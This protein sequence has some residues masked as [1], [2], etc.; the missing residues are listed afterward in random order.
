MSFFETEFPRTVGF[1]CTGGPS[2]NTT[3]NAGFSGVEQRNKNWSLARAMYTVDLLTPPPSQF[4]GTPQQFIDLVHGF[5]LVVSGKGDAFRFYDHK[6]NTVT[7]QQIGIGDGTNKSFQLIKSYTVGNRTYTR[8]IK[9]P[10][11]SA[12]SDY[13]GTALADT[14]KLYFGGVLQDA[15]T[16]TVDSTTGIVTVVGGSSAPGIGVVVT[17]DCKFHYPVRF[18]TDSFPMQVEESDV[19]GGKAII[20]TGNL[21]LIEVRI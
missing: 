4:S 13:K 12:V 20:S 9:K 21:N 6:D 18:D 10:I 8:T 3:V 17:A 1:K 7:G 2:F 14:V 16:Y 19:N 11:T 5:F 15:A